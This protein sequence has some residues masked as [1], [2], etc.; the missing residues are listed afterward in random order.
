MFCQKPSACIKMIMWFL[1]FF[2]F[3]LFGP[4][5]LHMRLPGSGSKQYCS[6]WYTPEPQQHRTRAMS[7]TYTT[8]HGNARSLTHWAR[9]GIKLVSSWML[10]R[11]AH[12]WAMVGTPLIFFFF[13]LQFVNVVYHFD[14][15]ADI[16]ESLHPW[17]KSCLIVVDWYIFGLS[18]YLYPSVILV[19]N[20]ILFFCGILVWFWYQGDGGFIEWAWE[21]SFLFNFL[22]EFV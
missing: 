17:N 19:C 15:F 8:V 22:E 9:P 3:C 1:C 16:E 11:F 7:A 6:C 18:L 21:Y 12:C 20:F 4:H 5:S 14:R 13:I 2:F 10:V